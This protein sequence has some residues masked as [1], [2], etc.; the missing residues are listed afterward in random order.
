MFLVQYLPTL[1]SVQE[2]NTAEK[3]H[4]LARVQLLRRPLH[5]PK[6][7]SQLHLSLNLPLFD[8]KSVGVFSPQAGDTV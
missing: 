3:V 7:P 1:L 4:L 8:A 5:S 6:G 2:N